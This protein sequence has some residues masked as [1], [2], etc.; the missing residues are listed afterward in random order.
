MK[1]MI[2][3]LTCTIV[4]PLLVSCSTPQNSISSRALQFK[5]IEWET[6]QLQTRRFDGVSKEELFSVCSEVLDE[7]GFAVDVNEPEIGLIV[8]S[9]KSGVR[10]PDQETQF[11]L[12]LLSIP[13]IAVSLLTGL[14]D[15][16]RLIRASVVVREIAGSD[17]DS[18]F[19]RV[20]F[21][22]TVTNEEGRI[23]GQTGIY[24]ER[25]FMQFFDELSKQLF[26]KARRI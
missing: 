2:Y 17:G 10:G 8:G 22:L 25:T 1:K 7:L 24:D 3:F 4:L 9:A 23:T 16:M 6:H 18:Y 26:R 20:V 14:F 13:D 5:Q 15:E 12:N 21:Q 11:L 19:V